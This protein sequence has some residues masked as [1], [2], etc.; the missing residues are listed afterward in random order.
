MNDSEKNYFQEDNMDVVYNWSIGLKY[1][2]ISL[3]VI[4]YSKLLLL[5]VMG[6]IIGGS[7]QEAIPEIVSFVKEN[8]GSDGSYLPFYGGKFSAPMV[9]FALGPMAR[10]LDF[11][12]VHMQGSHTSEF[13]VPTLLGALGLKKSVSGIDFMTAFIAGV[14]VLIRSGIASNWKDSIINKIYRGGHFIFGVVVGTGKMLDLNFMEL[15]NAMGMAVAKVQPHH[16]PLV[17]GKPSHLVR[18]KHA[19]ISQDAI[20]VCLLAQKGLTGPP[21]IMSEKE[22]Y[23][24]GFP[25][26]MIQPEAISDGLGKKW[27]I[28][29]TC[30]KP[31]PACRCTHSAIEAILNLK[32]KWNFKP[33]DIAKIHVRESS[34]NSRIVCTPP[35]KV[36]NPKT[37]PEAQFSLPYVLSVTVLTGEV[38]LDSYSETMRSR[39]DVR[40]LMKKVSFEEDP[41]LPDVAC[42]LTLTLK[43]G[44]EY[45]QKIIYPKGDRAFNPIEKEAVIAKFRRLATYSA[46]PLKEKVVDSLVNTVMSMEDVD[47]IQKRL[48]LP[49]VS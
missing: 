26:E 42:E 32:E 9:G 18:L 34:F 49:L 10:A 41:N 3:E 7:G 8:G 45:T 38:W 36:Y 30:M 15:K 46:F 2:D 39:T 14:E 27:N 37:V 22:G 48:V 44:L 12:D 24:S 25:K 17:L 19:F 20:T 11:G 16:T 40:E 5:D 33:A 1:S 31:F 43:N 21:N 13:V 6:C 4:D 28:L 35:E 47:D 23:L 29:D